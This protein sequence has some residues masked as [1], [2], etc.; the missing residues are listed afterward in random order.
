MQSNFPF[1]N[2]IEWMHTTAD[3]PM[4][5]HFPVFWAVTVVARRVRA[6][7]MAGFASIVASCLFVVC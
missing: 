5:S 3:R 1:G 6:A 7:K 4:T 2:R